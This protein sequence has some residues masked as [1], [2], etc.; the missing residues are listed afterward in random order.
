MASGCCLVA[1][2][3]QAVREMADANATTWVDQ[4]HQ[5]L[6]IAGLDHALRLDT[7][8]RVARGKLQRQQAVQTWSR[9][10]SLQSWRGLLGI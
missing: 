6:L 1:S 7:E 5:E 9:K 3:L 10:L 4:R 2:D 8:E